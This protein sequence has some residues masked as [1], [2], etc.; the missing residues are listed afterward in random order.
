MSRILILK[1]LEKNPICYLK[2]AYDE[3]GCYNKKDYFFEDDK[4]DLYLQ[5]GSRHDKTWREI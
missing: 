5:V 4:Y 3:D 1:I 2:V